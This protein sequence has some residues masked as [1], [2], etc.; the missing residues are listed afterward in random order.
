MTQLTEEE[1]EEKF[2]IIKA[3]RN[4]LGDEN[5][6]IFTDEILFS[7][8]EMSVLAFPESELFIIFQNILVLCLGR[9]ALIEK[10]RET[11]ITNNNITYNPPS[12]SDTLSTQYFAEVDMLKFLHDK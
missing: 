6:K 2:T 4:R 8:F 9:A 5:S 7:F 12:V 10:G 1:L 11:K 3:V